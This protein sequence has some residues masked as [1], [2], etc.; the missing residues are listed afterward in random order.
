MGLLLAGC[1][2]SGVFYG[3][4]F[5]RKWHSGILI[6]VRRGVEGFWYRRDTHHQKK[7]LRGGRPRNRLG[8]SS[9]PQTQP[10]TP[11]DETLSAGVENGSVAHAV[12][13]QP[14]YSV[15]VIV[16]FSRF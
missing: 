12:R 4:Q 7:A 2:I 9:Q 14:G 16:P 10:T 15:P 6:F 11:D 1:R 13:R 5:S 8:N 3:G